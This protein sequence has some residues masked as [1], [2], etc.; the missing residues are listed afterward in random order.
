MGTQ[1]NY[2]RFQYVHP[3]SDGEVTDVSKPVP[4]CPTLGVKVVYII[5]GDVLRQSLD[6]VFKALSSESRGFW[7][8]QRPTK[9]R[10]LTESPEVFAITYLIGT[11]SPLLISLEAAALTLVGVRRFNRPTYQHH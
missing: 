6:F 5:I 9:Y 4:L 10:Y 7:V 3:R 8:V 11:I 2:A 1:A